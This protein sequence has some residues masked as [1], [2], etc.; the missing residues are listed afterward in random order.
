MIALTHER[1]DL[2]LELLVY[3][4]AVGYRPD[5]VDFS[6]RLEISGI[7]RHEHAQGGASGDR[8]R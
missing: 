1:N 6:F 7:S 5:L 8:Y 3:V 4:V 2:P